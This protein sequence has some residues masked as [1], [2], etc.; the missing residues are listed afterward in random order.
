MG[1]DR[2]LQIDIDDGVAVLHLDDGKANAISHDVIGLFHNA[3]DRSMEEAEAV[4]IL[5]RPGRVSAARY[6]PP[7]ARG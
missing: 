4:A 3:L 5:G 7:S 6:V 2:P 1:S